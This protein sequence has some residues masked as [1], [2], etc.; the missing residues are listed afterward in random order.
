MPEQT[1]KYGFASSKEACTKAGALLVSAAVENAAMR[2]IGVIAAVVLWGCA[3]SPLEELPM[4]EER[5]VR[6]A[7]DLL[8]G[9]EGEPG[10]EYTFTAVAPSRPAW[11]RLEWDF[12]DGSPRQVLIGTL[13]VRHQF[14]EAGT[15]T[16]VARLLDQATGALWALGTVVVNIR[17]TP[18]PPPMVTLPAG[19]FLMGSTR[20]IA[21]QPVHEVELTHAFLV[22]QTEVTQELWTAVMGYNPS[23]FRGA[24]LPVENIT[25]WEAVEFCNRLSLRHGLQPCYTRRG[26]TVFW[27][28]TANGYRLPTEAEWEYACR[29]GTVTDTYAGDLRQPWGACEEEEPE[30]ERIAWYCRNSDDRTHPVGQKQPN[31]AGLFD[32]LGNVAEWVWDW[33][34]PQAYQRH[35]PKDP[36][37]PLSGV[38]RVVRGGAWSMGSSALRSA[39]RLSAS[40]WHH[41]PAVG[42]RIVRTP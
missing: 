14:V 30:L 10:K 20:D 6:I 17:P 18:P 15:Y 2:W 27:D 16:V 4:P 22:L 36:S 5:T 24:Q 3:E 8:G 37:G 1:Q 23:W 7:S 26:D 19:R 9:T 28:H 35:E 31:R 41:S 40:P 42:F 12:G 25:W 39:A 11:F 21:E 29:A 13:Q 33:F 32:M 38:R 34:D